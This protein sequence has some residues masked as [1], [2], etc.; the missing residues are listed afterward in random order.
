[1]GQKR[2]KTV[3]RNNTEVGGGDENAAMTITEIK[4]KKFVEPSRCGSK[5]VVRGLKV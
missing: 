3:C 4:Q 1:M 2:K 5:M